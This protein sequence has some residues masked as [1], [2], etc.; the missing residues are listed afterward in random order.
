M[1]TET[2]QMNN[3]T[4]F[5]EPPLE[6]AGGQRL[7]HPRDGITLFGPVDSRGIERPRHITYGLFGTSK[8][9]KS[10]R[11]F[12]KAMNQFVRTDEDFDDVLWP[13]F[14][15]FEEAFHAMWAAAPAWE[16]AIDD[17]KLFA[18]ASH[19][20]PY[21][22]VFRV[23][24]LFLEPI[25]AAKRRDDPF[26]IFIC[27]VP[28]FV[29]TNCRPL[30]SVHTGIGH[31]IS[32]RERLLRETMADFFES[33]DSRQYAYSIDFRRQIKARVME[34]DVPIQIIRES[35]LRLLPA[36]SGERQLTPLSDRAWNL[37]TA[38]YYKSGGK[39]WKL[40]T[41][42][43]GVCYVGI[44]FKNTQENDRSACSAAQMFLDDGDGVVFLGDYGSWYSPKRGEYHLTKE[45]ARKLLAGVLKTYADQHGKPLNEVFLH[46][47]STIDK[48]E[49]EGYQDACPAGVKLVGIRVA[50][51]R[52]GLRLYRNGTRPVLRGTFWPINAK[53]G[54]LWGSGFKPRLLTYDGS[55][56]PQPLCIEIQ[57]G[58]AD[59]ELVGK[60]I[61]GLTK[62]NYNCC[63]LGENQPVTIHFSDAVG[64]IL[65][66]N[67][68]IREIRPNFKYYI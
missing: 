36:T 22:R 61:L 4:V 39:P 62:L 17:A 8:G 31:R 45:A 6:F 65:V 18:A 30:S 35:T 5:S 10:F 7:D 50:P 49:F 68:G 9:I 41:A 25:K 43:D 66:A 40:S 51:E 44:T 3:L 52:L 28:D 42:R 16:Q 58:E 47:R 1:A 27:V 57:H 60:D 20:D 14:P 55:E 32:K 34:L 56:V 13:H 15:G 11:E 21:D 29:Y 2:A 26:Q 12:S 37:A 24:N 46:C 64:E 19:E 54:F 23:V 48:A 63:K 53:R 59:I 33:Y 38:F 67:R